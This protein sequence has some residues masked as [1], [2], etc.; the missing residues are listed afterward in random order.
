M[1][2][3]PPGYDHAGSF[4]RHA[5]AYAR[6]RPTY[7]D[8]LFDWIASVAPARGLAV[9]VATGAGQAALALAERF[10]RVVATDQSPELLAAIPAHPRLTT[11]A[12]PA[13]ALDLSA[14]APGGADVVVVAQALH[15]FATDAFWERVRV[16]TRHGGVFV[17]VGYG[18]FTIAPEIDAV[19]ATLVEAL[20]PHWSARNRLL[21]DGYRTI[22]VPFDEIDAPSLD[23]TVTWTRTQLLAYLGTWSAVTSLQSAGQDVIAE[24]APRLAAVWPDDAPRTITM[25]LALRAFR[26]DRTAKVDPA[27]FVRAHTRLVAPPLVP[28]VRLHLAD[29]VT[30]LW[31]ATEAVL[32]EAGLEPPFW[33]F[34]WPGSQAMARWILDH[35]EEVRGRT[36]L[37]I[38]AGAGLASIAAAWAGARATAN[39]VDPMAIVAARLNAEENA[40]DVAFVEGDLLGTDVAAEIVIVGDLCYERTLSERLLAWLRHLALTRRVILAEPGRAFAPRAGFRTLA[41]YVVPTLFDLENKTERT[42]VL[43]EIEP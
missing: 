21:F 40:A 31:Q 4:G 7:P 28:E 13:E 26:V 22:D 16:S 3:E 8:A 34:A 39:D 17:A 38:G 15:W 18:W 19:V 42:V 14:V 32:G 1:P 25:P 23:L 27:R 12:G 43:L 30:P 2:P 36:V 5:A 6:H 11:M 29:E 41:T 24:L 9:D 33:A 35:P 20:A 10:D 37:D